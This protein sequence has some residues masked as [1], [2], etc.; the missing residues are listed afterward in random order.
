MRKIAI[1]G[2]L[3]LLIVSQVFSLTKQKDKTKELNE[4]RTKG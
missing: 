2:A 1:I 3:S 4:N